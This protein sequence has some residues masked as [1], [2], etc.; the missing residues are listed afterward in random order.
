MKILIV[1]DAWHPQV[2]GV[3]TTYEEVIK[4]LVKIGHEV[5]LI[6]PNQYRTVA[7]P[8]YRE[9]RLS[10]GHFFSIGKQIKEYK[11]DAVHI[12]TEGPL[13]FAA[14]AFMRRKKLPYTSSYHTKFP[15]Y[16]KDK[17]GVPIV[18]TDKLVLQIHGSSERVLAPSS[19]LR[20]ELLAKG[21][22]KV[23]VWT[24][25]VD[26]FTFKPDNR[27]AT[28]F[29]RP[30]SVYVGRVSSEKNIECF[31][32]LNIP[33]EKVVVGDG[34]Q[35]ASYEQKYP[36]VTFVGYKKNAE[37]AYYYQIADVF[38]FPSLT[39]TFGLVLIEAMACG[40]PVAAFDVTGPR[41]SVVN[42]VNGFLG[43]DL[44]EI[45]EK[46]LT[47]NREVVAASSEKWSWEQSARSF[48]EYLAQIDW[49]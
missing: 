4:E 37:L 43:A 10:Y 2:S 20:E 12:A 7:I 3:V 5:E 16:V 31:L 39:D 23:S 25:G 26:R 11:P 22:Q 46:C 18:V 33:G 45:F 32:E 44:K 19:S 36:N 27:T 13:G 42:G 47:L 29:K 30:L 38:I 24:K 28:G 17:I 14:A 49:S 34:P 21:Y 48:T 6:T 40:T 8:F 41:E 1:T 15:E 35:R 9:I